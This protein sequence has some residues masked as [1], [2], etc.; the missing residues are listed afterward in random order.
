VLPDKKKCKK[1]KKTRSIKKGKHQQRC[2]KILS[3]GNKR[4]KR[5]RG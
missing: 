1:K 4:G 5:E 3:P 2:G